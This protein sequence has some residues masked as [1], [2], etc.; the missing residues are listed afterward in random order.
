MASTLAA[1]FINFNQTIKVDCYVKSQVLKI[2][3]FICFFKE[4]GL[5]LFSLRSPVSYSIRDVM[6][7]DHWAILERE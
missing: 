6:E 4:K 7:M 5:Y 3:F 1:N 2:K